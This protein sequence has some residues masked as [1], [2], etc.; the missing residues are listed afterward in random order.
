MQRARRHGRLGRI[1]PPKLL[2]VD[3]LGC[4]PFLRDAARHVFQLVSPH[5]VG[6][7]SGRE[8]VHGRRIIRSVSGDGA[9]HL[10]RR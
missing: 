8:T 7:R 6:S 10:R 1:A 9:T 2:I 5:V 3:E 4:L